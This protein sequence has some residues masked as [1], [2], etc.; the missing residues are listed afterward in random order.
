[1]RPIQVEIGQRFVRVINAPIQAPVFEVKSIFFGNVPAP[2]A[3]L[4][5]IRDPL[6]SRTLACS[7]LVNSPDYDLVK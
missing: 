6:W 2:H 1:M 4:V 5:N 7:T 3:V